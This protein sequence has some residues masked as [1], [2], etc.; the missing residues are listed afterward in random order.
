MLGRDSV[1]VLAKQREK[2]T[3]RFGVSDDYVDTL[4][5]LV[6]QRL[7]ILSNVKDTSIEARILA[8]ISA[9]AETRKI[10]I[11]PDDTEQLM[12]LVD[13]AAWEYGNVQNPGPMPVDLRYRLNNVFM[14]S[15][16]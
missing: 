16:R 5:T 9:F 12:L 8:A 4:M 11:N 10:N 3:K 6:K 2:I 1:E 13:I 14:H 15:R 7:G